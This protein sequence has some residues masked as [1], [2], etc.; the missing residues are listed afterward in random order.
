MEIVLDIALVRMPA[1]EAGPCISQRAEPAAVL[2]GGAFYGLF[3]VFH[4]VVSFLVTSSFR[5]SMC[6]WAK[7]LKLP[8]R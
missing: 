2:A 8:S 6:F 4:Y 3:F 5:F 1:G 7:M